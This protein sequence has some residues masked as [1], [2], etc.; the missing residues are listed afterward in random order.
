VKQ[1]EAN[2]V[3]PR[4]AIQRIEGEFV[5]FTPSEHGFVAT[6]VQIG[7]EGEAGIEILSGLKPNDPY[8][9]AGAFALK[10][11]MVTSGMDPHAGHGH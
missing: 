9:A 8:V 6:P 7:T 5:V 10:A 1:I 11:Q 2:V 3:V 4:E